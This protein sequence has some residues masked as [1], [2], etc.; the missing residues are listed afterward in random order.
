MNNNGIKNLGNTCYMNAVL[1]C[2]YASP[3]FMP[4]I[5]H[6]KY[7]KGL[8]INIIQ[9]LNHN[10]DISKIISTYKNT[11]TYQ[12]HK[13]FK[14]LNTYNRAINP[15]SFKKII[16]ALNQEFAGYG[17][18]DSSELLIFIIDKIHTELLKPIIIYDIFA[19]IN[20]IFFN[21][22]MMK[23]MMYNKNYL[24]NNYSII[25]DIF[26]GIFYSE[27]KCHECN[28]LSQIFEYY[29]ILSLPIPDNNVSLE[30]CIDNFF[31]EEKFNENNKYKCSKCNKYVDATKKI[32]MWESPNILIIQLKRF[33]NCNYK[34]NKIQTTIK[35]PFN[36]LSMDSFFC[37][38]NPHKCK[39]DLYAVINHM[40]SLNY[41]HY[42][43]MTKNQFDNQWYE[44]NDE[45]VNRINNLNM[46]ISNY[47]Y[48]LFYKK[49]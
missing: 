31:L 10:N 39:Y 6:K 34:Q 26:N 44:F 1:Q 35:Y 16:S 25:N 21:K 29:N 37:S 49:I 19:D 17:Q 8:K 32:Y 41:G 30:T 11:V 20:N 22:T 18:N 7:D 27:I 24:K 47:N 14:K 15:S 40:G 38:H 42:I 2:L 46:I 23:F 43:A 33:N 48:I 36:N 3:L 5:L 4:Y 45:N 28:E 9:L 13:V 12:L